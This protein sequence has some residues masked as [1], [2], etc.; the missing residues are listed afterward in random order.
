MT[1]KGCSRL[2]RGANLYVARKTRKKSKPIKE[3][4]K[5]KKGTVK[6]YA[7]ILS[8]QF[9][10]LGKIK[11][12]DLGRDR[13]D[14]IGPIPMNRI[15]L[16]LSRK[17]AIQL[18]HILKWCVPNCITRNTVDDDTRSTGH[19]KILAAERILNKLK[20]AGIK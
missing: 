9:S 1:F 8:K 19:D 3:Y 20:R 7:G 6:K 12:E 10:Q 16:D 13:F 14:L 18:T 11:Y 15:R 2:S 4:H 5:A 17:D